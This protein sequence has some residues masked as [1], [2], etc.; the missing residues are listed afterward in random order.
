MFEHTFKNIDEILRKD[1]ACTCELD[2]IEQLSWLLFLKY[3]DCLE[4]G[5]AATAEHENRR[6]NYT[7]DAHYRWQSWAAPKTAD[8]KLD[9]AKALTGEPLLSFVNQR[10]LPYLQGFKGR[11]SSRQTL[12]FKIGGVF[13]ESGNRIQNG[14]TLRALIDLVDQ[15]RFDTAEEKQEL[16]LILE[17]RIQKMG[18]SGR[19]GGE[20]F[21][22]R[23]L[24]QAILQVVRPRIGDRIYDGAVGTGGFLG[25]SLT[26]LSQGKLTPKNLEILKTRTFYG[27]EKKSLPFTL[28]LLSLILR[29]IESPNLIPTNSLAEA[30]A[31]L[32]EKDRYD[33]VLCNPPIGGLERKELYALYNLGAGETPLLFLQHLVA[34]LKTGGR[35]AILVK[36]T[37]LTNTDKSTQSVRKSLL[38]NCNI[39]TILDCSLATY[40]GS[41]MKTAVLFLEK[42]KATQKTWTYKVPATPLAD[43]DFSDFLSLQKTAADSTF[44]GQPRSYKVDLRQILPSQ[45]SE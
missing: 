24:I 3:L 23:P 5:Q 18:N 29:G 15:L 43:F 14:D 42:G 22:S 38:K 40:Q 17:A 20:F 19:N 26:F 41:P 6:F 1:P 7:F 16:S 31:E 36:N 27:K 28:S 25:E 11:A 33:I 8:G 10:L 34:N 9:S 2:Y 32:Q 12:E 35:G 13:E 37:F 30:T 4:T 44:E 21:T 45:A 39:H